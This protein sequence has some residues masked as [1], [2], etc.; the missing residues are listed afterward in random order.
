MDINTFLNGFLVV[1]VIIVIATVIKLGAT[2]FMEYKLRQLNQLIIELYHESIMMNQEQIDT[3]REVLNDAE[4]IAN[5]K[6]ID[7]A[8]I[9]LNMREKVLGKENG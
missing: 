5:Q 8:R 4:G 1:A 2:M 6:F 7:T 9:F 3:A